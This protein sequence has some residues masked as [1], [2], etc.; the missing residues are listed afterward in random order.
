MV[1]VT[2][3]AT[4]EETKV[5]TGD[6][7]NLAIIDKNGCKIALVCNHEENVHPAKFIKSMVHL[8]QNSIKAYAQ[9]DDVVEDMLNVCFELEMGKDWG[10]DE[11]KEIKNEKHNV[12]E[13]IDG[14]KDFL[15]VLRKVVEE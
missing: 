15:E 2:I 8:V 5:L 14:L 7:V 4:G 1:K 11:K 12:K 13:T 6:M 10:K 9:N 3:E